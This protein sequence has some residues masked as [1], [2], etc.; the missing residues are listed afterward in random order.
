MKYCFV[1][2]TITQCFNFFYEECI[3][4]ANFANWQ[5]ARKI[6]FLCAYC[7]THTLTHMLYVINFKTTCRF[8]RKICSFLEALVLSCASFHPQV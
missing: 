6:C 3:G 4:G 2:N 7:D 8:C 5:S 1:V